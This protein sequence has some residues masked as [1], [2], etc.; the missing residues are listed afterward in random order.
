MEI[1]KGQKQYYTA[2]EFRARRR[3]AYQ[4]QAKY[5]LAVVMSIQLAAS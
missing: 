2:L 4:E 3:Q 1:E 5:E